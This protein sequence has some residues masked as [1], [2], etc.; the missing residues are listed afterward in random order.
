MC[1]RPTANHSQVAAS[2]EAVKTTVIG[3][4]SGH[5]HCT[6]ASSRSRATGGAERLSA[7][8]PCLLGSN[9]RFLQLVQVEWGG[10]AG[11]KPEGQAWAEPLPHGN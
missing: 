4:V 11:H 2:G 6:S 5:L 7:S 8:Q 9:K 10:H 3:M 1:L